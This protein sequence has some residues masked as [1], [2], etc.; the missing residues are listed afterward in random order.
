VTINLTLNSTYATINPI[1]CDSFTVPSSSETYSS[2]GVYSDTIANSLG[3]D[4][5]IT[6]NLTVNNT[7]SST[8]SATACISY[9]GPSGNYTYTVAGVYADT[10]PNS[11]GCD[12]IVTINL[13]LNSTSSTISPIACDSFTVPSGDETYATTGMYTDTITNG[14]GCDSVITINLTVNP[15]PTVSFIGLDGTYCI[16][17]GALAD[18]LIGIPTGGTF[19]GQGVTGNVFDPVNSGLGTFSIDYSYTDVNGCTDSFSQEVFV[20]SC[21]GIDVIEFITDF[22]ISP[23]PNS[24]EFMITLNARDM[25]DFELR[26][27]NNLGQIILS[28]RLINIKGKFE[29]QLNL[30]RYP[31][32]IYNLILAS[33]NEEHTRK[34]VVE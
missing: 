25:T 34:V 29:K 16:D 32:G 21:T 27:V 18:T 30:K 14:L 7:S 20:T 15:L 10:I 4:S 33:E 9:T 1:V 19:S 28:E 22:H 17:G 24:G 3:C 13:T 2:T 5:V 26:I 31:S 6:I 12:S 11:V 23:N 8:I